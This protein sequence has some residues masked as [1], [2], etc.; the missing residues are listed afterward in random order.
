MVLSASILCEADDQRLGFFLSKIS[1]PERTKFSSRG[2]V[3]LSE[4][5]GAISEK[6]RPCKGQTRCSSTL[7]GLNPLTL[8]TVG[9][10]Q[11]RSPTAIQF[12]PFRMKIIEA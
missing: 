10:A 11:S 1:G 7:S 8:A 3:D 5:H 2:R 12:H 6:I 4:A 9:F